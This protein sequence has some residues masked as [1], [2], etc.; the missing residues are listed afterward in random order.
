MNEFLVVGVLL[1]LV[2]LRAVVVAFMVFFIIR[3]VR[4]CPACFRDTFPLRK[5]WLHALGFVA[6]HLEW[7]WCP[8]C[9]WQGLARR[10]QVPAPQAR[11]NES[12]TVPP[13]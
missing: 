7:R 11:A 4:A 6:H 5:R 10:V 2:A 1:G 9:D 12:S 8:F 3:P 13:S